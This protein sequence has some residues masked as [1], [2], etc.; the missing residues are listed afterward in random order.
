MKEGETRSDSEVLALNE[1]AKIDQK[2]LQDAITKALNE[3]SQ[4]LK[5][6]E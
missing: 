6:Q 1:V 5:M 2:G 4:E 3:K